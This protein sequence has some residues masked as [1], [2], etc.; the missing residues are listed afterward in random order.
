M[1]REPASIASRAPAPRRRAGAAQPGRARPVGHAVGASPA[2]VATDGAGRV[3][4]WSQGAED[5]F[6]WT[7]AE[8]IGVVLGHLLAGAGEGAS[9]PPAWR[10]VLLRHREGHAVRVAADATPVGGPAGWQVAGA[11][12]TLTP[13]GA[14]DLARQAGA[15]ASRELASRREQIREEEQARIARELHDELGQLLTGLHLDIAHLQ[16]AVATTRL[17]REKLAERLGEAASTVRETI[18]ATRRLAVQLRPAVLEELGLEAAVEWLAQEVCGRRGIRCSVE[19]SLSRVP[20][21]PRRDAAAFRIAQEALTNVVRHAGASRVVVRLAVAAGELVMSVHDDGRGIPPPGHRPPGTLG[22][23]GMAERADACG[24]RLRVRRA[25][26][27]GTL[28]TT[29]L[30]LDARE[31]A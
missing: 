27:G 19:S 30:P 29:R 5:L 7:A 31:R 11:V 15:A 25:R 13:I 18:V 16:R 17:A 6:G 22:I 24:G 2:V 3:T 4:A 20:P 23:V 9:T 10:D 12:Y 1:S 21:S 14:F 8:A 26:Q 28:V